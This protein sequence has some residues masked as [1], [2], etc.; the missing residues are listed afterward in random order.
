MKG[1]FGQIRGSGAIQ[2]LGSEETRFGDA[3]K[4]KEYGDQTRICLSKGMEV[5]SVHVIGVSLQRAQGRFGELSQGAK[6]CRRDEER[7]MTGELSEGEI[8]TFW[9][10]VVAWSFL[11][12]LAV[13]LSFSLLHAT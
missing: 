11:G 1:A 6:R 4:R 2:D 9:L 10:S 12:A 8:V 3:A 7:W 5:V 13:S